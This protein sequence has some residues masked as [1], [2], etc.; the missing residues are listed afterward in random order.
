VILEGIV[1]T[2]NDDGTVNVAPMGPRVQDGM[3]RFV[4]RPFRTSRTYHNLKARGEGVLHVTDDA[5]LF[6][7]SAVG[8]VTDVATR[9]AERVAGR[10]LTS[11]CRFYEFRVTDLDDREERTAIAA[12]CVYRGTF[13][14]FFGFNRAR[15]AVIE[16]AILA[17]RTDFIPLRRIGVEFRKFREIVAKT[18]GPDE[19]QALKL[20]SEHVRA[21][22]AA[23]GVP[24]RGVE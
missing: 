2:L 17:T 9:P 14:E 5:L 22:A 24:W 23:R 15:H 10:V 3:E 16:A 12:G 6:A 11:A 18:G 13:R 20:L 7:R 19:H 21:V 8:D 4:L 1:T